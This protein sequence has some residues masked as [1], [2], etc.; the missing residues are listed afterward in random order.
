M[1]SAFGCKWGWELYMTSWFQYLILQVV[2][3]YRFAKL[4]SLY[5]GLWPK[6]WLQ[7]K[8]VKVNIFIRQRWGIDNFPHQSNKIHGWLRLQWSFTLRSAQWC[9]DW[10]RTGPLWCCKIFLLPKVGGWFFF[11]HFVPRV[12]SAVVAAFPGHMWLKV[13]LSSVL[14]VFVRHYSLV[15]CPAV[16]SVWSA[17]SWMPPLPHGRGSATCSSVH[18]DTCWTDKWVQMPERTYCSSRQRSRQT[19]S[20]ESKMAKN[21]KV[22][23]FVWL[24]LTSGMLSSLMSFIGQ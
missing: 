17:G 16:A 13:H 3:E 11:V 5:A 10:V 6:L 2:G 1:A 4:I 22:I 20:T 21:L 12:A 7:W 23:Q 14:K 8:D 9:W 24:I 19:G 18:T 15:P